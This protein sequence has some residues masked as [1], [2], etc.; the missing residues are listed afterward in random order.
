MPGWNTDD[1]NVSVES[2]ED[3]ID[4]NPDLYKQ[5]TIA[6][7]N[8]K[9]Y[10]DAWEDASK[11]LKYGDNEDQYKILLLRVYYEQGNLKR[12]LSYIKSQNLWLNR[13]NMDILADERD[14]IYYVYAVATKS[15]N[16]NISKEPLIV[17]TPDG[18]GMY[19]SITNAIK[20]SKGRRPIYLTS[21]EYNE[22]LNISN[23]NVNL[24][25]TIQHLKASTIKGFIRVNRSALGIEN[26]NVSLPLNTEEDGI[27]ATMCNCV[28]LY[29][30]RVTAH[31]EECGIFIDKCSDVN[32]KNCTIS[33]SGEGIGI[34]DSS[35]N[36]EGC[37]TD[38]CSGAG[39]YILN[40]GYNNFLTKIRECT[41]KKNLVGTLCGPNAILEVEDCSFVDNRYGIAAFNEWDNM[42]IERIVKEAHIIALNATIA[43]SKVAGVAA[44]YGGKTD[45][46]KSKISGSSSCA[47]YVDDLSTVDI[48]DSELIRNST[49]YGGGGT[50][51]K[52]NCRL[53]DNNTVGKAVESVFSFLKKL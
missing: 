34:Q 12:C 1:V 7:L 19:D 23:Y 27:S 50:Y 30:V 22:N 5:R 35:A 2:V 18:K 33:Y 17:L 38:M 37:M 4:T 29:N 51:H 9:R 47:V 10:Q 6:A 41:F 45:V 8:E 26:I 42:P 43:D 39:V 48:S 25:G 11:A 53:S 24:K 32:I 49:E 21:G 46:K 13:E 20:A 14:F 15:C 36:I 16:E 40:Y 44:Y 3:F 31:T 28:R 52:S